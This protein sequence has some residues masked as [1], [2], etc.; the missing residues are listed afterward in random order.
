MPI[1]YAVDMPVEWWADPVWRAFFRQQLNT[2]RRDESY[3]SQHSDDADYSVDFQS[4]DGCVQWR[5]TS[6]SDWITAYQVSEVEPL[7]LGVLFSSCAVKP[8]AYAKQAV[9]AWTSFIKNNGTIFTGANPCATLATGGGGAIIGGDR[10]VPWCCDTEALKVYTMLTETV[11]DTLVKVCTPDDEGATPGGIIYLAAHSD[12][13]VREKLWWEDP[14]LADFLEALPTGHLDPESRSLFASGLASKRGRTAKEGRLMASLGF[15]VVVAG[16]VHGRFL[17]SACVPAYSGRGGIPMKLAIA[18]VERTGYDASS[19]GVSFRQKADGRGRVWLEVDAPLGEGCQDT[20]CVLCTYLKAKRSG[21]TRQGA[22]LRLFDMSASSILW[23][24]TLTRLLGGELL[25]V[26]NHG[27]GPKNLLRLMLPPESNGITV[28][29]IQG[30]QFDVLGET[31]VAPRGLTSDV[32]DPWSTR[33]SSLRRIRVTAACHDL[34]FCEGQRKNT[35]LKFLC[36]CGLSVRVLSVHA[37]QTLAGI[38]VCNRVPNLVIVA[39]GTESCEIRRGERAVMVT[40][41]GD[42]PYPP[43][44]S[45]Y[46]RTTIVLNHLGMA[47]LYTNVMGKGRSIW[48]SAAK[49]YET[50]GSDIRAARVLR[51]DAVAAEA[52]RLSHQRTYSRHLKR[53]TC[54]E[55]LTPYRL[56]AFES[57]QGDAC[58]RGLF[59]STWVEAYGYPHDCTNG[60]EL[61]FNT[62]KAAGAKKEA[63]GAQRTLEEFHAGLALDASA[64]GSGRE[65]EKGALL[66]PV[67][68]FGRESCR[69]EGTS[70]EPVSALA[71]EPPAVGPGGNAAEGDTAPVT[72][73]TRERAGNGRTAHGCDASNS[74]TPPGSLGTE[75]GPATER[76]AGS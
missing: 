10:P 66:D 61:Y 16:E 54:N 20:G 57:M 40:P 47:V 29:S 22:D 26:P 27:S 28:N 50:H 13:H 18:V 39:Q 55:P 62:A 52:L 1:P 38:T 33:E 51:F 37:G 59:Y 48:K 63:Q 36:G 31:V 53:L 30:H 45:G 11:G 17:Q 4:A 32:R 3:D 9:S 76:G 34:V 8:S 56:A 67:V 60:M 25:K 19:I 41:T 46:T 35:A 68:D 2:E 71:G 5:W 21:P 43:R 23:M 42:S 64:W 12:V 49:V 65:A 75:D 58:S 6:T 15:S 69:P 70:D 44:R 73:P 14:G 72:S 74:S 24:G 7:A